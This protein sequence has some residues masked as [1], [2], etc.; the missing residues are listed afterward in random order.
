[1]F[2]QAKETVTSDNVKTEIETF[3]K[4]PP[5]TEL[6]LSFNVTIKADSLTVTI[7]STGESSFQSETNNPRLSKPTPASPSTTISPTSQMTTD[8]GKT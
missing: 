1:M 2:Y 4:A 8:G 6:L 3:L 7:Q 5:E